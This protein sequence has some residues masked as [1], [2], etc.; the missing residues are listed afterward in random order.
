MPWLQL[1]EE[2]LDAMI[3]SG[4]ATPRCSTQSTARDSRTGE[5]DAPAIVVS[6]GR[7]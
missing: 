5:G 6:G 3:K 4:S 1:E 7:E 2:D